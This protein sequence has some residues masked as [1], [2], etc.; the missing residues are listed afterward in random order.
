MQFFTVTTL[1]I[2]SNHLVGSRQTEMTEMVQIVAVIDGNER[3]SHPVIPHGLLVL[4]ITHPGGTWYY[5]SRRYL[6]LRIQEVWR[7][8]KF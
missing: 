7:Y 4:G 3:I 2:W 5:A 6:V 1:N 8:S